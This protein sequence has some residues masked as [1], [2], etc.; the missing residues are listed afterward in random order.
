VLET[1][2]F[3]RRKEDDKDAEIIEL[4]KAG[5]DAASSD[6]PAPKLCIRA[7][8]LKQFQPDSKAR[9]VRSSIPSGSC[10]SSCNVALREPAIAA[11]AAC[12]A[13]L[14]TLPP[15]VNKP[16]ALVSRNLANLDSAVDALIVLATGIVPK[17]TLQDV[18]ECETVQRCHFSK[19]LERA[20][21]ITE[22]TLSAELLA[23]LP[24]KPA[25]LL[26]Q[27]QHAHSILQVVDQHLPAA[28]GR[29]RQAPHPDDEQA[30]NE[31]PADESRET[32]FNMVAASIRDYFVAP[33][34][35]AAD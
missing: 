7:I 2:A 14:E 35:G 33:K 25:T 12:K 3:K 32:L 11:A 18:M 15:R 10:C 34:D 23:A 22:T 30:D 17:P 26:L 13:F 8:L 4:Y 5:V 27:G 29:K 21:Y 1:P 19:L 9:R 16:R 31:P 20:N 28:I 24:K 6:R